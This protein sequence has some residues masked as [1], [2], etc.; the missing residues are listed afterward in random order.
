MPSPLG[1]KIRDRRLQLEMSLETLAKLTGSSKSYVWE[2]E[3]RDKDPNPSA[4]KLAKIAEALKVT[5]EFFLAK[6]ETTPSNEVRDVAFFR[7]YLQ[8]DESSKEK[9]RDILD[10]FDAKD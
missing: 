6:N 2:L 4:E 9:L 5:S 8:L 10:V 1:T 3:N 7:K